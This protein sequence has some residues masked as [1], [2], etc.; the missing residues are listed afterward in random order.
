MIGNEQC[1]NK[2]AVLLKDEIREWSKTAA[3]YS[4]ILRAGQHGQ[5]GLLLT[6]TELDNYRDE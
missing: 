2:N 3:K 1:S 6:Y 5:P 4:F